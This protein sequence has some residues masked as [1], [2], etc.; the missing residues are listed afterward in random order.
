MRIGLLGASAIAPNAVIRPAAG[1]CDV[2]ITAIAAS[3]PDKARAYADAH[4]IPNVATDYAALVKRDD[5]DL[6]YCALPPSLHAE[7]CAAA[8]AAGKMV[9]LEKP[10]A[11]DA[12]DA[13]RI[14]ELERDAGRPVIE[15]FHYFFHTQFRRACDLVAANAIGDVVGASAVFETNLPERP[16][17]LRWDAA[18]GG[19]AMMDLGCYTVHALRSLLERE[20][21]VVSASADFRSGVDAT[22]S[23]QLRFDDIPATIGCSLLGDNRQWLRLDGSAGTLTLN[24]F[25]APHEGGRLELQTDRGHAIE[26]ATGPTTY[27][28]QLEHVVRVFRGD[29]AARTGGR[30]AIANMVVVDACRAAARAAQ[31]AA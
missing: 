20:P 14:A 26:Q 2:T 13:R 19:G 31:A 16:G 4:D 27:Q 21:E 22:L 15:A 30:D 29:E 24:G 25:V 5:V 8:L 9:L 18:C 3:R 1:R 11:F 10:Y 28:A 17:E 12:D 6:V 23:A 7:S